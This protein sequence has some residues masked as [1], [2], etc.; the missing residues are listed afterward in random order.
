M[1]Y[2][3]T[4]IVPMLIAFNA[5][6]IARYFALSCRRRAYVAVLFSLVDIV[7]TVVLITIT[8]QHD[9]R[10]PSAT[11]YALPF[12]AIGFALFPKLLPAGEFHRGTAFVISVIVFLLWLVQMPSPFA[13]RTAFVQTALSPDGRYTATLCYDDGITMGYYFLCLKR[14]STL[15]ALGGADEVAEADAEGF[16]SIAW[17]GNHRL[18]LQIDPGTTFAERRS[19]WRD[20]SLTYSPVSDR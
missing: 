4:L 5:G 15:A 18:I 6:F 1:H 2:L 17:Q 19:R 7:V 9:P 11:M 8:E 20:V 3:S 16:R 13:L 10:F 14:N 12:S